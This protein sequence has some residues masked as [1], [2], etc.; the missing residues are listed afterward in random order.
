VTTDPESDAVRLQF[1]I[2]KQE[3][4]IASLTINNFPLS[5]EHYSTCPIY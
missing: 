5:K 2:Y 4:F 1:T 3:N